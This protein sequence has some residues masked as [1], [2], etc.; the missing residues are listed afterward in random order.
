MQDYYKEASLVTTLN[1]YETEVQKLPN[2]IKELCAWVQNI[3]FHAYW[4]EKYSVLPEI[5]DNQFEMQL[6]NCCEILDQSL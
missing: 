3:L 4:L 5:Q 2:D 6:Q 1:S